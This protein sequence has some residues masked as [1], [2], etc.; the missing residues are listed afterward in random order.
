[1]PVASKQNSQMALMMNFSG[2]DSIEKK[3]GATTTVI[4]SYVKVKT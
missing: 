3:Y 4:E 1:V 2:F